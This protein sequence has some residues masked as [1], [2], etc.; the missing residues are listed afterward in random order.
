[1]AIDRCVCCGAYIP[2]GR[3]VCAN[4]GRRSS[5][6]TLRQRSLKLQIKNTKNHSNL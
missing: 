3:Q 2:E 5:K 1:M 6:N 4:C